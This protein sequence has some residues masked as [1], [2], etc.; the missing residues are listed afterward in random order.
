[1]LLTI[2]NI[3]WN[4]MLLMILI[5]TLWILYL[6]GIK[7]FMIEESDRTSFDYV[8]IWEVKSSEATSP[9][10]F[11]S[12]CHMV[13]RSIDVSFL[14]FDDIS[15]E[16]IHRNKVSY[17]VAVHG[18]D[19]SKTSNY[20]ELC[21]YP[22]IE[23]ILSDWYWSMEYSCVNRPCQQKVHLPR[24]SQNNIQVKWGQDKHQGIPDAYKSIWTFIC[25]CPEIKNKWV[26][27]V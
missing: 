10:P 12:W 1:M 16:I 5:L 23:F 4:I 8:C 18:I 22:E 6:C 20:Q 21:N 17:S 7:N 3:L 27:L 15:M 25:H 2:L 13:D 26:K 9:H 14:W 19:R 11:N 24:V